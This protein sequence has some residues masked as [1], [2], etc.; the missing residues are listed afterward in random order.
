MQER[1]KQLA[2]RLGCK[3]VPIATRVNGVLTRRPDI[4]GVDKHGEFIMV[5][6]KRMYGFPNKSHTDLGGRPHPDYFECERI[7][8]A[9]LK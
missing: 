7:L 4:M 6:P 8:Y 5:I 3:I 9:K 1:F 2:E